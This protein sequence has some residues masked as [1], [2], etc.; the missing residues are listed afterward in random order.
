MANSQFFQVT[1]LFVYLKRCTLKVRFQISHTSRSH[2]LVGTTF[3]LSL[4]LALD[5][6]YLPRRR[7]AHVWCPSFY[8]CHLW[9][10]PLDFLA[11]VARRTYIHQY[12]RIVAKNQFFIG[13]SPRAQHRGNREIPISQSLPKRGLVA[14]LKRCWG[15][16][17]QTACIQV[18]TEILPF[19]TLSDLDRDQLLG[20]I[21]NKESCLD[22][23]KGLRDSHK[24]LR[25][26]DRL[27]G[28]VHFLWRAPSFKTGGGGY[29]I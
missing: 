7:F 3:G 22:N 10:T 26:R 16:G 6:W 15:P 5:C 18:L 27:N 20:A 12:H 17:F 25:T 21:K 24:G 28:K 29:L 1:S 4:Y 8:S 23:H 14:N 19:G 9:D 11:L 13:Y 2:L